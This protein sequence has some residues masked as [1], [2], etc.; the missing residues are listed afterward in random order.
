[1][2]K[3]FTLIFLASIVFGANAQLVFP[4]DFE[5]GQADTGWIIFANG[6]DGS[7]ADLSI[8]QNPFADN[9]NSSDSVLQFIVHDDANPWVGMYTDYQAEMYFTQEAHTIGMMVMKDVISPLRIKLE[10]SLTREFN[11]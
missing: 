9:T 4:Y 11:Y 1:M 3:L 5:E 2:K 8:V 10:I 7:Q 6:A